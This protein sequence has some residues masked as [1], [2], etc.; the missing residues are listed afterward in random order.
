MRCASSLCSVDDANTDIDPR[1]QLP[2]A[3]WFGIFQSRMARFGASSAARASR[4]SLPF[5]RDHDLVTPL[6]QGPLK[7]ETG[8]RFVLSDQNSHR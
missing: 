5:S 4:A 6:D 1:L 3:G 2:P 8:S 7:Q